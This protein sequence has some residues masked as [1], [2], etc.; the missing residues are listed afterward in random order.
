MLTALRNWGLTALAYGLQYGLP[1]LSAYFIFAEETV[2]IESRGL[3][4]AFTTITTM[5]LVFAFFKINGALKDVK[6]SIPK[7]IIKLSINLVVFYGITL[8]LQAVQ[9]NADELILWVYTVAGST[10]LS[11]ASQFWLTAIDREFVVR[12]GVF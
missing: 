11:Y 6:G 2:A 1:I 5:V 4:A 7:L 8:F 12:N 9:V 3:G 10:I